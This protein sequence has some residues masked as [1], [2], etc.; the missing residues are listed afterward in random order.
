M[1][2]FTFVCGACGTEAEH[3]VK[4]SE[5]DAFRPPCNACGAPETSWRGVEGS[6]A[7]QLSGKYQFRLKD[8]AGREVLRKPPDG[9]RG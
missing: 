7:A 2:I 9:G 6:Q 4:A 8:A 1:P 3:L 5:R